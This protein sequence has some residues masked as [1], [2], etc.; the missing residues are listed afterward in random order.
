MDEET[1]QELRRH[2]ATTVMGLPFGHLPKELRLDMSVDDSVTMVTEGI[3][4]ARVLATQAKEANGNHILDLFAKALDE[5]AM[6]SET[7][8][9]IIA[10]LKKQPELSY[11][12]PTEPRHMQ[13]ILSRCPDLFDHITTSISD[14]KR[15]NLIVQNAISSPIPVAQLN[16]LIRTMSRFANELTCETL[17]KYLDVLEATC[18]SQKKG[19]AQA[20][21]VRSVCVIF[22]LVI[23]SNESLV[24]Q[25]F[26]PLSS[27]CLSYLWVKYAA[28]LYRR[29]AESKIKIKADQPAA[30]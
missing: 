29:L 13:F 28:D 7:E 9:Q 2:L 1:E 6:T 16:A 4:K 12:V 3:A 18:R 8:A 27:F 5:N 24:E 22:F 20:Y 17:F 23:D 30:N 15:L 19:E 14:A 11:R 25:L 10:L 26:I 21:T